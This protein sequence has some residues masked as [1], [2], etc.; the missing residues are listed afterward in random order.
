MKPDLALTLYPN[1]N[2]GVLYI[3]SNDEAIKSAICVIRTLDGKIVYEGNIHFS[4]GLNLSNLSLSLG[5]YLVELHIEQTGEVIH[6]Q[7][8]YMK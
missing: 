6:E 5:V 2:I 1:P 3:Q 7:L 4:K 8:I